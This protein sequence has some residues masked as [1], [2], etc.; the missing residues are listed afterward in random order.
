MR[1]PRCLAAVS[2]TLV[3]ACGGGPLG[4]AFRTDWEND[5]GRSI[6]D[7]QRR[8]ASASLPAGT[9]LAVGVTDQ[10]LTAALLDGSG[11]KWKHEGAVDGRPAITGDVVVVAGGGKITA[12]DA[13]GGK[14]LWAIPS[15][16]RAVR[17]AGDDGKTTV[18]SLGMASGG[19]SL[20]VA[21]DRSGS[22]LQRFEP[23]VDVG[24]P[25]VLGG[26][27]FAPWGN[28]YVS[29][30]DVGSGDEIGRL[31]LRDKVSHAKN[32]GGKLFFGELSLVR[33]DERVGQSAAGGARRAQLPER[34]LAGTP[35]WL[36]PGAEVP[37][38]VAGA[39]DKIRLYARPGDGADDLG[40][41]DERFVATYFRVVVG[42]NSKDGAL[43][44]VRTLPHDA[45][46]GDAGQTGFAICDEKGKVW[47]L[48]SRAGGDAGTVDLGSPLE[49]CVVQGGSLR[50]EGKGDGGPVAEQVAEAIQLKMP[51]MV[52]A[53][54]FL[55]RELGALE[56]ETVSRVLVDLASN[57][58]T[59]P[60]LLEDARKLLASRRNGAE[61]MLAALQ[62]HY[63]FLA[64]VLLPPP[65]GP[66]ADALAAMGEARAAP[67]LAKHL[68]DPANSPD[69]VR[70]AAQ[71]LAKI[72]T[73]S[74]LAEIETFF[75]LYRATADQ[76]ELV[77]AVI[78]AAQAL[79][80]VGG[81]EGAA[82]VRRAAADP[83]THPE[84]RR[85][86]E[87]LVPASDGAAETPPAKSG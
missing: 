81:K 37:P 45:I 55:L 48:G 71:A 35:V 29:A 27:I 72:A 53:Q 26:V 74:E 66:L 15:D 61:F 82:T 85:G 59:P 49:A 31:L 18:V 57:P 64:D 47:L 80:K 34:E 14:P 30:I 60:M 39:P 69:D 21:V 56:D 10:G 22:V 13:K 4:T 84:V 70:R 3:A 54:R 42:L 19:G 32:L 7:V 65:V 79:V 78:A 12:L 68:N 40:F 75:A 50:A 63:D 67:L 73:R 6:A 62:K 41:A 1:S 9:P 24:S 11:G 5:S 33:F 58:Q 46:A 77:A 44:W 28:Q 25:A 51:Q 16:G 8:L 2:L 38:P 86:I 23:E 17:G 36:G 76:E 87:N 52:T 20:V 43:R 83:L